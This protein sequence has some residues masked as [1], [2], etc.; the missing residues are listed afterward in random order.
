ML[1]P[2]KI[3]VR[4]RPVAGGA[5]AHWNELLCDYEKSGAAPPNLRA[6]VNSGDEQKLRAFI[7][8][9]MLCRH[10]A[11]GSLPAQIEPR[12]TRKSGQDGP[13]LCLRVD[14]A[15]VWVEATVPKPEGV[16]DEWLGLFDKT[17]PRFQPQSPPYDQILLRWT[18]ALRDK[19]LQL[20]HRLQKGS[21]SAH[22]SYVVAINSCLLSP[23]P[24]DGGLGQ[25][26]FAVQATFPFGSLAIPVDAMTEDAPTVQ[27]FHKW[28]CDIEKLPGTNVPTDNFLN[29]DYAGISA[30]IGCSQSDMVSGNLRLILVHNPLAT[31]RIPY[32]QFG[33]AEEY[34]AELVN[35]ET[36]ELKRVE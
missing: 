22:D 20:N 24:L 21:V 1:E 7:W 19:M 18:A 16:P 17:Q 3:V 11:T 8:E 30:L 12:P 34:A 15:T 28:R 14:N 5:I 27:A 6:E 31:N 33:A 23:F 32:G 29:P 2:D 4:G 35:P 9:A 13:D 36:Y 25:F 10:F 26:P